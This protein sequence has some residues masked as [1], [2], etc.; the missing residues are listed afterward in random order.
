MDQS[1]ASLST[2][3]AQRALMTLYDLLPRDFW[4]GGKRP[5]TAE[6][7]ATAEELQENAPADV[8]PL[9]D[10]LLAEGDSEEKG[11]AAKVLLGVF[12]DQDPLRSFV[13][14]A[15]EQAKQPHMAPIPLIVGAVI[16]LLSGVDIK[17]GNFRLKTGITEN[18]Q[19]LVDGVKSLAERLPKEVV[20]RVF[21]KFGFDG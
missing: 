21:E 6:I 17:W 8:K 20:D 15:M 16:V 3:Q 4:E 11:E 2:E 13:E 14:Q 7:E 10:A 12:Y 18:V 9:V 19:A 5:S 1:I